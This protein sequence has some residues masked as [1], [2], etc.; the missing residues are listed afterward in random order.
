MD[1]AFLDQ[2]VPAPHM[3]LGHVQ[4]SALH[5][6]IDARV[7]PYVLGGKLRC[8][9]IGAQSYEIEEFARLRRQDAGARE[10]PRS[11]SKEGVFPADD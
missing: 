5:G 10:D 8:D 7:V 3:G 4:E 6:L 11:R 9:S 2:S 1:Q